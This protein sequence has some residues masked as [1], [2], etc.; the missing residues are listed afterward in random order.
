MPTPEALISVAR[1]AGANVRRKQP[2]GTATDTPVVREVGRARQ[3]LSSAQDGKLVGRGGNTQ[4]LGEAAR[5]RLAAFRPSS[6]ATDTAVAKPLPVARPAAPPAGG[7]VS[8]EDPSVMTL[9]MVRPEPAMP[10]GGVS[11]EDAVPPPTAPAT[12]PGSIGAGVPPEVLARLR[13]FRGGGMTMGMPMHS[14]P[15]VQAGGSSGLDVP[16]MGAQVGGANVPPEVLQQMERLGPGSPGAA[17]YRNALE[18]RGM[19]GNAAAM[20]LPPADLAAPAASG[21]VGAALRGAM[22]GGGMAKPMPGSPYGQLAGAVGAMRR[23]NPMAGL[24][25]SGGGPGGD[26]MMR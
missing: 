23:R 26:E 10:P 20:E 2:V 14:A 8:T 4:E 13:A 3:D 12:S 6:P 11:T 17:L 25:G 19:G 24:G 16:P 15:S 7:S 21:N 18:A 1:G 22:P 9:P 5:R